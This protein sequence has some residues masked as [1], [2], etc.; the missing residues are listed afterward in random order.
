[1]CKSMI[2]NVKIKGTK[3]LLMNAPNN[4]GKSSA[5]TKVNY[6]PEDEA[7]SVTYRDDE[8]KLCVPALALLAMMKKASGSFKAPGKGRKTLRDF[9]YSGLMI[10]GGELLPL[11]QQ[12]YIIDARPVVIGKA[13]VMKWRP[14]IKDWSMSFQIE[15]IDD[16]IWNPSMVKSIMEESGKFIGLLDFR[17][18]FGTFEIE[19]ITTE[20]G[21]P[22]K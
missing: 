5:K 20:D 17:P 16:V 4:I 21:K 18:L 1:M 3:P 8:G 9:V 2:V 15:I 11:D 7:E 22:V 10:K 12:E 6:I 13:R 19:T 14:K